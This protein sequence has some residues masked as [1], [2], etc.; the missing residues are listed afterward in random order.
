MTIQITFSGKLEELVDS[1]KIPTDQE[2]TSRRINP[3]EFESDFCNLELIE[4]IHKE[5]ECD[6]SVLKSLATESLHKWYPLKECIYV[7]T[8][9]SLTVYKMGATA[10]RTCTPFSFYFD[11][12]QR[13]RKFCG[14]IHEIKTALGKLQT[15]KYINDRVQRFWD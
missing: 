8:S 13:S 7:F 11:T 5:T 6:N 4:Q 1:F 12:G 3:L 10:H 14:E 15:F 9:G 2:L